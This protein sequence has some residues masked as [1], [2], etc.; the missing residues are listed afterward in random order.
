MCEPTTIMMGV[1][2]A[3]SVLGQ[4]QAGQAAQASGEFNAAVARNNA[5]A[6]RDAAGVEHAIGKVKSAKA[7]LAARQAAGLAR[8]GGAGRGVDV[9]TGSILD[10]IEDE[11]LAGQL[12]SDTIKNN[13]ARRVQAL[14]FQSSNFDAQS[15][16]L[17]A[18][19]SNAASAAN[20]GAF[21]TLATGGSKVA[22]KWNA[23]KALQTPAPNRGA[24]L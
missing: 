15:G 12:A 19:G 17:L 21:G 3:M 23:Y 8:A 20:I 18:E 13:T 11:T 9:N 2:V 7:Q 5:Q 4:V 24:G 6:A 14:T 22:T 16:L 1:G 10:L